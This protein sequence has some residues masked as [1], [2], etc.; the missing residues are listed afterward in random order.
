M[1]S[2]TQSAK[3]SHASIVFS[4]QLFTAD[5][6]AQKAGGEEVRGEGCCVYQAEKRRPITT[7]GY[8]NV[9]SRQVRE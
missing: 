7:T 3:C 6:R 5:A 2:S 1:T 8:F 9:L 4:K